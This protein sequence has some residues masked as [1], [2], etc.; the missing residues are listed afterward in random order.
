MIVEDD[1][2]VA[3]MLEGYL[4]ALGCDVAGCVE[5]VSDAISRITAGSIDAA[6]LDVH[7]ANGETSEPVAVVLN[8]AHIPYIVTTG[9]FNNK[10]EAA[11]EDAPILRKPF[12]MTSLSQSL[13]Q[14]S[15]AGAVSLTKK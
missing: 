10:V 6:I 5:N 13:D 15:L 9:D 12:T 3:M 14:I 4:D 1:P 11:F 8:A 7:L 2:L